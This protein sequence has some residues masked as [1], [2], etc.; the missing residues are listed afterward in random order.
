MHMIY[1]GT[2]GW[3]YNHWRGPFYPSNVSNDLEFYAKYS[4]LNEINSTFYRIPTETM[5][6]GWYYFTPDDFIFS[7][8]L[9]RDITHARKNILRPD[10]IQEFISRLK[11]G[12]EEKFQIILA[13]FPPW[14]KYSPESYDFLTTIIDETKKLF[15]GKIAIEI[16]N[17]SWFTDEFSDYIESNRLALVQTTNFEYPKEFHSSNRSFHYIRL[18]GDRKII[19][20]EKL[21]K[22]FLEKHSA[23]NEWVSQIVSLTNQYDTI[24]VLI[25]NRFSGYAINDAI[26]L[27]K[28]LRREKLAVTGFEKDDKYLKRQ[29][30]LQEFL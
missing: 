8:K 10:L 1:L 7:A 11:S 23:L 5:V 26:T 29:M 13:Q 15:D 30:S 20:N 17:K 21:G 6:R 22:V 24:F 27:S 14:L 9:T 12:L 2:A 4:K 25:N 19:P 18:L 28:A 16:R 3:N